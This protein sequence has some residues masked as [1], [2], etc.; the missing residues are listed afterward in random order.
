MFGER[1]K[2][3]RRRNKMSQKEL[4][5]ALHLS[6]RAISRYE[7]NESEPEFQTLI[8]M[9]KYFNVTIDYLM[10]TDE[11]NSILISKDD[12]DILKKASDIIT[13]LTK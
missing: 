1:L 7:G 3:L 6:Q 4:G 10:E 5:E 8:E 2:E 13:K 12:F 9:A 11:S